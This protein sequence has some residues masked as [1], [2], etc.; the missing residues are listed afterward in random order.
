MSGSTF[1]A[2]RSDEITDAGLVNLRELAALSVLDLRGT[3]VT[4]AGENELNG[5]LPALKIIR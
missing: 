4:A 1:R 3:D 5:S 2:L